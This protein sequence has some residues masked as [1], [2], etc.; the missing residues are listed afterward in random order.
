MWVGPGETIHWA[1][2]ET[3]AVQLNTGA[4]FMFVLKAVGFL[5]A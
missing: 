5:P 3:I 1:S 2:T 4:A